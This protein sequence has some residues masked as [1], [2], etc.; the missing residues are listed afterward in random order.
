M[1]IDVTFMSNHWR[2]ISLFVIV[3]ICIH[4]FIYSNNIQSFSTSFFVIRRSLNGFYLVFL[5][6]NAVLFNLTRFH[7]FSSDS[8]IFFKENH[9]FAIQTFGDW[10]HFWWSNFFLGFHGPEIFWIQLWSTEDP[11]APFDGCPA[12]GPVVVSQ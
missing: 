7:L 2:L 3:E 12:R 10:E 4:S 5:G 8:K 11:G 1:K 9:L 6:F